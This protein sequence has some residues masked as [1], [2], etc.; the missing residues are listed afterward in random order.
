M[1]ILDCYSKHEQKRDIGSE[2]FDI[3]N[4]QINM[5]YEQLQSTVQLLS[6][7]V[8]TFLFNAYLFYITCFQ[9]AE[10]EKPTCHFNGVTYNE[11]ES[12]GLTECHNCV[13]KVCITIQ[14]SMI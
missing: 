13:C 5:A 4:T 10:L 2:V 3:G 7:K 11:G 6:N 14:V 1:F 12:W 8:K 9:V